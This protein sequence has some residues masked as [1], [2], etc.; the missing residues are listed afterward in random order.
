[1]RTVIQRVKEASV[2]VEGKQIARI[3][4][5]LLILLGVGRED[6]EDSIAPLSQKVTNLRIFEDEQGKMN[7]SLRDIKGE[8]LLVPQFT[9]YADTTRGRRPSFE[10]AALPDKA[11]NFFQQF[12]KTL[13]NQGIRVETGAFGE[14]MQVSLVNDGP[15]TIILEM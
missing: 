13:Q 15:V 1:M 6:Q 7:L 14:H 2:S 11:N 3:G 9:L 5:G 8:I 10:K 4:K 12:V